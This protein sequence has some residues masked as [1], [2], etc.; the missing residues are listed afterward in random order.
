MASAPKKTKTISKEISTFLSWKKEKVIGHEIET[1]NGKSVVTKIWCKMCA[2]Y[3]EQLLANPANKG[4]SLSSLKAFTEGTN[5]VT[6]HQVLF[7]CFVFIQ[8]PNCSMH[9]NVDNDNCS[10]CSNLGNLCYTSGRPSFG[11]TN[12]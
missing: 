11:R 7:L 8:P 12:A 9:I 6:K 2:K 4:C 1:V 5:V 10:N 3:K